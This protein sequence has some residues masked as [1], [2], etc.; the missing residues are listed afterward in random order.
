MSCPCIKP[1]NSTKCF[2]YDTKM[3]ATTINEA[4]FSF[5]DISDPSPSR[6]TMVQA[7]QG[8][9]HMPAMMQVQSSAAPTIMAASATAE[10]SPYSCGTGACAGCK[11]WVEAGFAKSLN[12][13]LNAKR[14][15]QDQPKCPYLEQKEKEKSQQ[16]ATVSQNSQH[17]DITNQMINF[18][19]QA[20]QQQKK[21]RSADDNSINEETSVD[22]DDLKDKC[23]FSKINNKCSN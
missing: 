5:P 21:K 20:G 4:L 14:Q 9:M 18:L 13:T 3:M 11:H 22:E 15:N 23:K 7:S 16:Q 6:S 1:V 17:E 8:S 12:I 10:T 19:K 2:S